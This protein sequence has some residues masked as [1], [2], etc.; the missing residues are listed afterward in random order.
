MDD[1]IER[2]GSLQLGERGPRSRQKDRLLVGNMGA[3]RSRPSLGSTI[4]SASPLFCG[5]SDFVLEEPVRMPVVS[6]VQPDDRWTTWA[7]TDSA[8][9]E[10]TND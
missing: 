7:A 8:A 5:L 10:A 1:S 2:Q 9:G 6:Y 3:T 4:A